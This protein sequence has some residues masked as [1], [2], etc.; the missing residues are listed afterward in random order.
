MMSPVLLTL[1]SRCRSVSEWNKNEVVCA[2]PIAAKHYDYDTTKGPNVA[3]VWRNCLSRTVYPGLH[4]V[5]ITS[6]PS[7]VLVVEKDLCLRSFY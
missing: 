3:T 1:I 4:Q 7:D 2:F 6:V 5:F